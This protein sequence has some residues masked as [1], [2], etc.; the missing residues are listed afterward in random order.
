MSSSTAA[1]PAPPRRLPWTRVRLALVAAY[2][3][4]YIWWFFNRG[5]II[6]RISVLLSV[7]LFLVVA[8]V[9]RP[10]STGCGWS[11]I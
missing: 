9:G 3:A 10:P 8:S 5:V 2:A 1:V 7:A 6:D 11:A 4:G